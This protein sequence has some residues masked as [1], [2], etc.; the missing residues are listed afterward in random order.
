MHPT[1]DHEGRS[2]VELV[3]ALNNLPGQGLRSVHPTNTMCQRR[4]H[5]NFSRVVTMHAH[6]RLAPRLAHVLTP[7]FALRQSGPATYKL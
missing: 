3:A 5:C 4:Y 6:S 2:P 7:G 1:K